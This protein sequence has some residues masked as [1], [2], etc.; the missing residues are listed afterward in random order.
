MKR[1][2]IGALVAASLAAPS[3]ALATGAPSGTYKTEITTTVGGGALKGLWTIAF[4]NGGYTVSDNGTTVVLGKNTIVGTKITF[5]DK[6]GK[7]ACAAPG[8]YTFKLSGQNLKFTRISDSNAKCV[9]RTIVLAGSF[10]HV[11]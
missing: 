9:G 1:L 8:T 6:S 4:K 7:A 3:E 5:A 2:A 11:M 10:T